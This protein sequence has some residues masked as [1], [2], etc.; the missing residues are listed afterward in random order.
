MQKSAIAFKRGKLLPQF[1][2]ILRIIAAP[3]QVLS[4]HNLFFSATAVFL[5]ANLVFPL[6]LPKTGE[7]KLEA[8]ILKQPFNYSL[9]EKLGQ[10]YLSVN[11]EAA[12]REY[13]LAQEYYRNFQSPFDTTRVLG[14]QAVNGTLTTEENAKDE[15]ANYPLSP[16]SRWEN[17]LSKRKLLENEKAYWQ[18]VI[19]TYPQYQYAY[20]RLAAINLQEEDFDAAKGYIGFLTEKSPLDPYVVKL[21]EILKKAGS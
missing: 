6:Y 5:A 21:N 11:K 3:L 19:L 13:A 15:N 20:M 12:G 18:S 1:P 9:H 17:V 2:H 14:S 8:E 7:A 10:I 4:F 16:Q